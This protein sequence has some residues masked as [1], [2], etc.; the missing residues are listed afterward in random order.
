[1]GLHSKIVASQFSHNIATLDGGVLYLD[2]GDHVEIIDS[3]LINNTAGNS[4]GVSYASS[5]RYIA[6]IESQSKNAASTPPCD[7]AALFSNTLSPLILTTT[8]VCDVPD[9]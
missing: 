4:G 8:A 7:T 1:M 6:V 2:H 9:M 5:V 3:K